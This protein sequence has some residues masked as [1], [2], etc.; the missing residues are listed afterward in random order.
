MGMLA[1]HGT[2][3]QPEAVS[4]LRACLTL[5][6]LA[7]PP[8]VVCA[9]PPDGNVPS[10]IYDEVKDFLSRDDVRRLRALTKEAYRL[11]QKGD[12]TKA[13]ETIEEAERLAVGLDLEVRRPQSRILLADALNASGSVRMAQGEFD[14]AAEELSRALKLYQSLF[15]EERFPSGHSL[16]AGCLTNLGIV[17]RNKGDYDGALVLQRNALE[18]FMRIYPEARFPRGHP[19]VARNLGNVG[20]LFEARGEYD[21]A[22]AYH[23]QAL[24]M[25]ERLFPEAQYPD[26]HPDLAGSMRSMAGV[27]RQ[28]DRFDQALDYYTRALEM[29]QR[30]YPMSRF[31]RGHLDVA[32][33]ANSLGLMFKAQGEYAKALVYFAMAL[34][35]YERLY[36]EE[37]YPQGHPRLAKALKDLGNM[38]RWQ[39]EYR[40]ALECHRRALAIGERCYP[41]TQYSQGHP[42]L[43]SILTG[44]AS[45]HSE[46]GEFRRAFEYNSQALQILQ[47]RYPASRYPRGHTDIATV[48]F[49]LG[50]S[51]NAMGNSREALGYHTQSLAMWERLWP[52]DQ[53]PQG[54]RNLITSLQA[55]GLC[56]LAQGRESEARTF[57]VRAAAMTQNL[58]SAFLS[59]ASEAESL[60]FQALHQLTL[61]LLTSLSDDASA[62]ASDVYPYV[63][64]AKAFVADMTQRRQRT[65]MAT[66]DAQLAAAGQNLM[67]VR[68][69]LA[70]LLLAPADPNGKLAEAIRSLTARKEEMERRISARLPA[71]RQALTLGRRSASEL[72]H[73]LGQGEVFVDLVRYPQFQWR[74]APGDRTD[75]MWS[76]SYLAFVMRQG[77]ERAIV[78]RLGPAGPIDKAVADWRSDISVGG[79]GSE[80]DDLRRLV[81]DKIEHHFLTGTRTVY[82]APDGA[83][84]GMPWAALPGRTPGSVLLED[85]ALAVV[86]SGP[87]LLDRLTALRGSEKGPGCLLAVGDVRYDDQPVAL[88]RPDAAASLRAPARGDQGVSW[89]SLPA[90]R[91]ELEAIKALAGNRSVLTLT[92]ADA[93]T[94]RVLSELPQARWALIATHGFFADPKFR[95]ALQLDEP[96]FGRGLGGIGWDRAAPGAR[97][98]LVLSGLVLAGAN[99]PVLKGEDGLP[100]GDGGILTAEAVAGL[101]L[102]NLELVVLSACET[103]LGEV[104]GGEG[105]FGLQRAFHT[106]GA[107]DVIAT[108]WR[109]DDEA[110][111]ALM[112]LFF[113]KLWI[114][115]RPPL[116]ALRE[117]QL[118][119]YRNPDRIG[120]VARARGPDFGRQV[121]VAQGPVMASLRGQRAAT[122]LW[123]GFVLSG[124]GREP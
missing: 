105:V 100:Q 9:A 57:L 1:Q 63:W 118:F 37:H 55:L 56:S 39:G 72:G 17:L 87:F 26:G 93:C 3:G 21:T 23:T 47:W 71:F 58:L 2:A 110:T 113:S 25:R 50:A 14:E 88:T 86:P 33:S 76:L 59:H 64:S 52:A 83:L 16:I 68:H 103:G 79:I 115:N 84:T 27:L 41:K 20:I 123:A 101:P 112:K 30:L 74:S 22:L 53:Y 108:L 8:I 66:S 77:E 117:A 12:L 106:A 29:N 121:T 73:V 89:P 109:V 40:Q 49:R 111:A 61:Y 24:Q 43:A 116:T 48:L 124:A 97:N 4:R 18:M 70:G 60:N 114:E 85:Y 5:L 42:E 62:A 35:M 32:D 38:L 78:T 99:L 122:R 31:P 98:P 119:V 28:M 91:R 104:A 15:P 81:W 96:N 65:L 6:C 45:D 80:A 13:R 120:E 44:L 51:A 107:H 95:S 69:R 36:P 94:Y 7:I 102:Q 90:T 10:P 67:A 46:L 11:K 75:E 19:D 92:G 34:E 82:L 54:H